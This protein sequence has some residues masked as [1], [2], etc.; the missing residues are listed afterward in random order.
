VRI[1]CRRLNV[2]ICC[3]STLARPASSLTCCC[4]FGDLAHHYQ[5]PRPLTD[6]GSRCPHLAPER[7]AAAIADPELPLPRR[8]RAVRFEGGSELLRSDLSGDRR[9]RTAEHGRARHSQHLARGPAHVERRA[10]VGVE[11]PDTFPNRIEDRLVVGL[12]GLQCALGAQPAAGEE[13][14]LHR[15]KQEKEDEQ[16]AEDLPLGARPHEGELGDLDRH[17]RLRRQGERDRAEPA[18]VWGERL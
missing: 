7:S 10:G 3:V 9:Q 8:R 2:S 13:Q 17:V 15:E 6:L 4:F 1:G 11:H 12:G 18:G 5:Q 16:D 14:D